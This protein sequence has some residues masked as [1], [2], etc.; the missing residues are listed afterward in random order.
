MPRSISV[1]Y[2]ILFKE[3]IQVSHDQV[4][5]HQHYCKKKN[6]TN[7]NIT[8]YKNQQLVLCHLGTRGAA[9]VGE[10]QDPP[11]GLVDIPTLFGVFEATLLKWFCV[12][13]ARAA[14][15]ELAQR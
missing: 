9:L 1:P 14:D 2:F 15:M 6:F 10:Y 5:E 11:L 13:L 4:T 3:A 8:V 7:D 12:E